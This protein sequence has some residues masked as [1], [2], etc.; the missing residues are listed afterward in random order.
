LAGS[1]F[2]EKTGEQLQ[3]VT[4]NVKL[5]YRGEGERR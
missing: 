4:V 3:P 1:Q 5:N 2:E